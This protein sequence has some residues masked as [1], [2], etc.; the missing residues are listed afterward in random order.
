MRLSKFKGLA[1]VSIITCL[2]LIESAQAQQTEVL[3]DNAGVP[4]IIAESDTAA[5]YAFGW[6]QM[7]AHGNMILE[8]Y[9]HARGRA[10]E[11]WGPS[12][13]QSDVTTRTLGLPAIAREWLGT[14]QPDTRARLQAFVNGLN[15]YARAYP[16]QIAA[17][18]RPV[19]P[20]Q[21]DDPL[22]Y[23]TQAINMVYVGRSDLAAAGQADLSGPQA[24]EEWETGSNAY[25]IGPQKS[26]D[27]RA[28][29]LINPHLRWES[30]FIW[31]E[32]HL[33]TPSSN[34]YGVANVGMPFIGI[35]F[36]EFGGWTHTVNTMD[37]ADLYELRLAGE[38]YEF[39]GKTTPFTT[40]SDRYHVKSPNGQ[41]EVRTLDVRHSL[42]GPVIRQQGNRALA[43][44]LS[45]LRM[46]GMIDQYWAMAKA[47]NID[48]FTIAMKNMQIP[49]FNTFYANRDGDIYF[50]YGAFL[51]DRKIGDSAFWNGTIPGNQSRF[52]WDTLLPYSA[53]PSLSNPDAGFLQNANEP[54]WFATFPRAL[55]PDDYEAHI[56]PR[57]KLSWRAQH[58][59]RQLLSRE[60]IG[61]DDL[62]E[63][64]ESNHLELG[65]RIVDD[66]IGAIQ[67]ADDPALLEVRSVL[68]GWDRS[69]EKR[70]K[71]SILFI[72][73]SAAMRARYGDS[74]F[75][76]VWSLD[77]PFTTPDGLSDPK[78]ALAVLK[79]VAAELQKQYGRIDLSYGD[80]VYLRSN[81]VALRVSGGPQI[82]GS[83][84]AV[85]TQAEPDGTE[86]VVG[87]N[88]F[89]AVVSFGNRLRASGLLP[90]GNFS[91]PSPSNV[92]N[93]LTAYSEGRLRDL[94][95]Y[96][97]DV[98]RLTVR[99]ECISE[100]D[101][102]LSKQQRNRL[103]ENKPVKI[104][105]P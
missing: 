8:L 80:V 48:S 12:K 36:S 14:M 38:G 79:E 101:E 26:K 9:G 35:G 7:Q 74:Y 31:F 69:T 37:G 86:T 43:L 54:P 30:P 65:E 99:R 46:F 20:I 2:T 102:G 5:M 44:R 4:H 85:T 105:Q 63:M 41:Q 73:W 71:G 23:I 89:Y 25:A 16:D 61:F 52:L 34:I 67:S 42:H 92:D 49:R 13:V 97:E 64:A 56:A 40:T 47:E 32:A 33:K 93:Q 88:T 53:S 104:V 100:G 21:P 94:L 68:E 17:D 72:R 10:A 90:Y 58:S 22:A 70:S 15:A 50:H 98:R 24:S 77:Q 78:A 45:T 76:T 96:E 66:L 75:S 59:L 11:Y 28:M 3:W 51:P 55:N 81:D 19:L 84:R 39:D 29:L 1:S 60:K 103:C 87:G 27:G 18:N 6:S 62:V 82:D 57:P 91:Q 95:Y 83:F